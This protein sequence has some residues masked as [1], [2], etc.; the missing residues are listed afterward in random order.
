MSIM[1]I[2]IVFDSWFPIHDL[3][4]VTKGF[5]Y[6][7]IVAAIAAI[8]KMIYPVYVFHFH[9][10]FIAMFFMPVTCLANDGLL[11]LVNGILVGVYIQAVTVWGLAWIWQKNPSEYL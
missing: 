4:P 8:T 7:V 6:I 10:F 1:G 5:T 2:H 9:H 11:T 3:S